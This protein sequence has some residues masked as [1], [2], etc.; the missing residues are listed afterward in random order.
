MTRDSAG[1]GAVRSLVM[2]GAE[3]GALMRCLWPME[4]AG[5]EAFVEQVLPYV[6]AT[7]RGGA[8]ALGGRLCGQMLAGRSACL[9]L[10]RALALRG[11]SAEALD[12]VT[13]A[14]LPSLRSLEIEVSPGTTSA[15]GALLERMAGQLERVALR[16]EIG[17]ALARLGAA[18][19]LVALDISGAV[20][21]A[22]S[23]LWLD[24]EAERGRLRELGL[25]GS[26]LRCARLGQL[27]GGAARWAGLERL[28]VRAWDRRVVEGALE[29]ARERAASGLVG[30]RLLCADQA[31]AQWPAGLELEDVE[32]SSHTWASLKVERV[33]S[34]R[35][36]RLA[37][38]PARTQLDAIDA[39]ALEEARLWG[40]DHQLA[41]V[42]ARSPLPRLRSLSLAATG[43]ERRDGDVFAP[44][45]DARWPALTE[46]ELGGGALRL[47]ELGALIMSPLAPQLES[48]R[49]YMPGL[50]QTSWSLPMVVQALLPHRERFSALRW[51]EVV[52][53]Y[54]DRDRLRYAARGTWLEGVL[55]SPQPRTPAAREAISG[56]R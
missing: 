27:L 52:G 4:R 26:S 39:P 42:L 54:G 40:V 8:E 55:G 33:A 53:V 21:G 48:L 56:S 1:F 29:A 36:R 34:S 28:A 23:E 46:L 49:L 41:R 47:H 22:A 10:V 13:P 11:A 16:G 19:P 2:G 6:A 45:V 20:L 12:R 5:G 25:V 18:G 44:L 37:M 31:V 14:L 30:L 38:Y 32:V 50:S 7:W 43:W 3:T 24:A 9:S 35:T 17:D 51:L 15:V